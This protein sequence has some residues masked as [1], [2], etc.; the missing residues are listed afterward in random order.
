M[1]YKIFIEP[2]VYDKIPLQ[3][4]KEVEKKRAKNT[5]KTVK[6]ISSYFKRNRVTLS[7]VILMVIISSLLGLLG[8]YL[9]G[10]AIDEFIVTKKVNGL[11]MLLISSASARYIYTSFSLLRS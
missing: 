5:W 1:L 7:L 2:F 11:M 10:V 4:E 8:P 6:R 3:S 9:V